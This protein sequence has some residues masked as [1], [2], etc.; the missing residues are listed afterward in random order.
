M[1]HERD[2][3]ASADLGP[4]RLDGAWA[5]RTRSTVRAAG[6]SAWSLR[7][8]RLLTLPVDTT[9]DEVRIAWRR[10][11]ESVRIAQSGDVLVRALTGHPERGVVGPPAHE[12]R[13]RALEATLGPALPEPVRCPLRRLDGA[14]TVD[15]RPAAE[16]ESPGPC[17]QHCDL[18]S[19]EQIGDAW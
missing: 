11:S 7:S 8:C 16:E 10:Q 17:R 14:S 15:D 18:L 3:A 9:E 2:L 13:L 19:T 12:D 5:V 1:K 6:S 4:G